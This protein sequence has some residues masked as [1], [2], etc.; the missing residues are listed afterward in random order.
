MRIIYFGSGCQ[1][2]LTQKTKSTAHDA[3]SMILVNSDA[4]YSLNLNG[5]E[6]IC[7]GL[8]NYGT[9]LLPKDFYDNKYVIS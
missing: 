2:F 4:L 5:L 6:D 3:I 1:I 7:I 8:N 9:L